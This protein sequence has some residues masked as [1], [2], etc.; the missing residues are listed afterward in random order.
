MGQGS[1]CG[2]KYGKWGLQFSRKKGSR[3]VLQALK[4]H[5][6]RERAKE[7]RPEPDGLTTHAATAAL[8]A[9][10]QRMPWCHPG[11]S[12]VRGG[13]WHLP[14]GVSDPGCSRSIH[15][16]CGGA[17]EAWRSTRLGGSQRGLE[18][19]RAG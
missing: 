18:I 6:S 13:K 14:D 17:S 4:S 8:L 7:V 12:S 9:E 11:S 1:M 3:G 10:G 2:K 15:E 16:G 19:S 5:K